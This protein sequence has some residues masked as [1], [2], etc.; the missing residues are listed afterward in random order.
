MGKKSLKVQIISP[1]LT[2]QADAPYSTRMRA[3][4]MQL[5]GMDVEVF[6]RPDRYPDIVDELG[7][8]YCGLKQGVSARFMQYLERLQRRLGKIWLFTGEPFMIMQVGCRRALERHCDVVYIADVEPWVG[9]FLFLIL[10][11]T[12][13]RLPIAGLIPGNYNCYQNIPLLRTKFRFFL[14][15]HAARIL[16]HFI[17][18]IGTSKQI[19]STLHMDW[20]THAHVVPEGYEDHIGKRSKTGARSSLK[21]PQHI[22]M[23]LLFGVAGKG[24]GADILLKALESVPPT[25]MVCIVGKTGGVYEPSWGSTERLRSMGWTDYLH[26]VSRYVTEEEIQNYYAA[27]DAVVIPYIRGFAG[28]STHLRR[29]S[30]YGK[31]IIACDQYHIG[32]RVREY[33]LGLT[34]ETD[35]ANS[36]AECL[37]CFTNMTESWFDQIRANSQRLVSDESWE[38]VGHMYRNLFGSML[39]DQEPRPHSIR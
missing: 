21:L 25:F 6:A 20:S 38:N 19:L 3:R 39:A 31:A 36:L 35:N 34:F 17:D 27:C 30:E 16:P 14:N 26:I 7:A 13:Y 11:L 4:A 22:P 24:K 33:A 28:T 15:Y 1:G 32:E 23:I 37:R 2:Y 8:P 9:I 29:A 12:Q 10:S 18:V 5:A